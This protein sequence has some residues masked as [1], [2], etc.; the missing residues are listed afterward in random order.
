MGRSKGL[1]PRTLERVKKLEDQT[2]KAAPITPKDAIEQL[3]R[4]IR[5]AIKNGYTS[6]CKICQSASVL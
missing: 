1:E 6:A 4:Q 2:K 3:K 5:T